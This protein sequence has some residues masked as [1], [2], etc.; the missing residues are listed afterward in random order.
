[1][2]FFNW[3]LKP[4]KEKATPNIPLQQAHSIIYFMLALA[5]I[6]IKY[7]ITSPTVGYQNS[8]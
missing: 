1:M 8:R 7:K 4:L 6:E 5:R 2:N 3:I